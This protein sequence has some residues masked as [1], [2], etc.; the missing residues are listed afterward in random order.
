MVLNLGRRDDS[1][2]LMVPAAIVDKM[3]TSLVP[4]LVAGDIVIDGGSSYYQDDIRRGAELKA[5]G[6]ADY[7]DRL[8]SAMR[9]QFG[10]HDEKPQARVAE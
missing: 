7:A 3:L 8:L 9:K 5:R 2:W 1:I 4:L 10:G 6:N